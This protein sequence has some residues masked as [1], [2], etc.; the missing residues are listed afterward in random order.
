[1]GL[2]I[3]LLN[4]RRRKLSTVE[5]LLAGIERLAAAKSELKV[6]SR[7]FELTEL[8]DAVLAS[9]AVYAVENYWGDKALRRPRR[10]PAA[11]RRRPRRADIRQLYQHGLFA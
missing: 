1:M 7:R 5:A 11:S 4:L 8:A 9:V 10:T 3:D 6:M 2:G